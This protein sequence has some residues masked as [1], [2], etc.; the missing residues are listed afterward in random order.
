MDRLP[1][2]DAE[3]F[4]TDGGIET[5]LI[6][7]TGLDLP[8]FAAF[9]LL[10]SSAGRRH[11]RRYY[12][13]YVDIA[14]RDRVGIVLETPTWRANPDWGARLGY[15]EQSLDRLNQDAVRLVADLRDQR[16]S[17]ET[18]V[19]VS[20]CLG[21]RG[22]GY[23]V[24]DPMTA[25]EAAAYHRAQ[26]QSFAAAGADLVTAITMT[27]AAEAT[28]VALSARA[29]GVPVVLSFTV[30]TDGRLPS[31]DALGD[32]IASVDAATDGY[33]AYYMLNCAHP[34]HFA[35]VLDPGAPGVQ[36]IRGLRANAS[37]K[38]H[39]ELDEAEELD[40]GNPQELA[41]DYA[42]LRERLP[43][44]TVLGGCCGTSAVH[45]DAISAACT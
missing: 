8:D 15:G 37:R 42:R 35:D 13:G 20:G 17:S 21:P 33:P 45:I 11:L 27:Y 31:G 7:D 9:P 38:S 36:R 16:Q 32:A 19:V 34:E 10:A 4:L 28:G 41:A 26:V 30:E 6:Y 22:D 44:L 23:V 3:V 18:P 43:H 2:L 24:E 39:T 25:D 29:A 40:T 5:C 14:L 12:D 1:Q